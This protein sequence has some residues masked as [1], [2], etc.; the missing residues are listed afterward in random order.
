MVVNQ[1][2]RSGIK[3]ERCPGNLPWIYRGPVQGPAE[4]LTKFDQVVHR[5]EED[6]GEDFSV[7]RRQFKRKKFRTKLCEVNDIG[8]S[9]WRCFC[10]TPKA[11]S[12]VSCSV[13]V[14]NYVSRP[15]AKLF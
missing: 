6:N 5:V 12:T 8:D 4:H 11:A 10:K 7:G 13:V 2:H 9:L 3:G 15:E 14:S 1:D